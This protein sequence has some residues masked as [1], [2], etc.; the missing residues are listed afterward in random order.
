MKFL[1]YHR[2]LSALYASIEPPPEQFLFYF[3]ARTIHPAR[4][5]NGLIGMFVIIPQMEGK[6]LDIMIQT[7]SLFALT[8]PTVPLLHVVPLNLSNIF[9][10]FAAYMYSQCACCIG[11][12]QTQTVTFIIFS[13]T[14]HVLNTDDKS[15]TTLALVTIN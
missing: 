5:V 4:V 8:E 10:I 11:R 12:P 15:Q 7:C 2:H 6:R 1:P 13:T 9:I 14:S 3:V